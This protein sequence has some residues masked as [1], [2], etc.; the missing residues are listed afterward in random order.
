MIRFAQGNLLDAG[1]EALVNTVN[2]VGVMGKG[3]ALMFRDAFP[4]NTEEYQRAAKAQL[5]NVGSMFVTENPNFTGPRW[6]INFPTKRH[7]RQPSR[8]EWIL[9][10]LVDLEFVIRAKGIKSVAIPALGCGNGGLSWSDV[11]EEI[12]KALGSIE[13]VDVVVYR[14]TS[15][16]PV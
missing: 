5:V 7:W 16:Y 15:E 1:T 4:H 14:P 12:A 3:I 6:I 13:G 2:E 11:K 9:S 8:L 10:G